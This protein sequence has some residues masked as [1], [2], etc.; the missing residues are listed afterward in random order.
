MAGQVDNKKYLAIKWKIMNNKT[1][2][3]TIDLN[4]KQNL[5]AF[6]VGFVGKQN[7]NSNNN[8]NDNKGNKRKQT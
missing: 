5:P 4:Q 6:I 1:F 2:E 7:N 8:S 3:I